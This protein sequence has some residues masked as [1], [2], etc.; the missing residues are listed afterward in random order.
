V[1]VGSLPGKGSQHCQ[2]ILDT[3]GPGTPGPTCTRGPGVARAQKLK[4]TCLLTTRA[5]HRFPFFIYGSSSPPQPPEYKRARRPPPRRG[6]GMHLIKHITWGSVANRDRTK[7]T[8][9]NAY[10]LHTNKGLEGRADA[11]TQQA[12]AK[13]NPQIDGTM[14]RAKLSPEYCC[15]INPRYCCLINP[16]HSPPAA[17]PPTSHALRGA[18]CAARVPWSGALSASR[19]CLPSVHPIS[20]R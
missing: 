2:K 20:A 17:S 9:P 12:R 4:F 3:R 5:T 14:A 18:P 6:G 11:C 15:L 8:C 10:Q 13:L 19:R 16:R 7:K 1:V